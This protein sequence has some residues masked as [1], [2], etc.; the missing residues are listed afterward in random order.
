[1]TRDGYEEVEKERVWTLIL[2]DTVK[3]AICFVYMAATLVRDH[4]RTNKRIYSH[5][6]LERQQMA[7]NGSAVFMLGDFS[8]HLGPLLSLNPGGIQGDLHPRNDN[9]QL[10]LD[11][12]E[13]MDIK[14]GLKYPCSLFFTSTAEPSL[15]LLLLTRNF[16]RVFPYLL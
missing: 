16:F 8:R 5:I 2:G 7:S 9:G 12:L 4:K 13:D 15:G 11:F 3:L 1:M 6:K 10:L 14:I